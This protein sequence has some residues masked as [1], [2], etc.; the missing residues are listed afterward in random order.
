MLIVN[1]STTEKVVTAHFLCRSLCIIA[2]LAANAEV[3]ASSPAKYNLF[4]AAYV[5]LVVF[6]F[7]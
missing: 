2:I 3:V 1:E 4:R 6:F 7:L 5:I